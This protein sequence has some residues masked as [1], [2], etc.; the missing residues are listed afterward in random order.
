M[1]KPVQAQCQ[2]LKENFLNIVCIQ[3][4][5]YDYLTATVI[6]GLQEL[7]HT[8][9][10]S[11]SSNGARKSSNYTVKAAAERADLII[12]FSNVNVRHS[13]VKHT[14]NP[15]I[16]FVDGSD[17]QCFS[18]PSDMRFKAIFKRELNRC[19][20]NKANEPIFP[21]PFAAEN[22]YFSN[23]SNLR[24]ID[25]SFVAGLAS[26][27]VRYSVFYR[28]SRLNKSKFYIGQ[29]DESAYRHLRIKGGPTPTP[30]FRSILSRS[31]VSVNVIGG[32]YDCAR[33]WEILASG[34]MLL[35]QEL[36]I[37]IPNPFIDGETCIIFKTM[38]ELDEKV[39][40]LFSDPSIIQEIAH[41]GYVHLVNFHTTKSRAQYLLDEFS[42][43]EKSRFCESFFNPKSLGIRGG[44]A[45]IFAR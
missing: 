42:Q 7:G 9:V 17:Q 25:L 27:A 32:G 43:I 13:L 8:I 23:Q 2:N 41:A 22:R 15:N 35:T 45:S 38:D 44:F 30:M 20:S 39:D 24:D 33:Y 10:A 29:T 31:K 6:E 36:E 12:V 16:I 5:T 19:W 1:Q 18:V 26:N 14:N 37:Q 3:S 28:L 21:L 11:E 40:R 4:T 34:A